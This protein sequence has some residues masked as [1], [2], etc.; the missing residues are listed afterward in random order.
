MPRA[1]DDP[2]KT[3]DHLGD[4]AYVSFNGYSYEF[5]VNDHRNPVVMELEPFAVEALLRFCRRM[6]AEAGAQHVRTPE[7]AR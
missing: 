1:E 3:A 5:R 4:G 6:E 7:E 2:Y